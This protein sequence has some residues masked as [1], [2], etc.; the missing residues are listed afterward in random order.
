MPNWATFAEAKRK[1][2]VLPDDNM[3]RDV[4]DCP[5]LDCRL[6]VASCGARWARAE[7]DRLHEVYQVCR[8]CLIGRSNYVKESAKKNRRALETESETTETLAG[9]RPREAQK[10]P[11]DDGMS[12]L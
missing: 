2:H 5:R 7:R 10:A 6:T 11:G 9:D 3:D 4:Q 8:G 12:S 1:L